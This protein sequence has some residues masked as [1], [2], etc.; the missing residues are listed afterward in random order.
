VGDSSVD[1]ITADRASIKFIFF[2]NGYDDGVDRLKAHASF[3]NYKEF[4]AL[5]V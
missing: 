2:A 5:M 1:Q 4:S 3:E